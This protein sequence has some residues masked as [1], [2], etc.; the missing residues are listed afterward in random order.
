[1]PA[2]AP[3]P[4]LTE[5][6]IDKLPRIISD[7]R[8]ELTNEDINKIRYRLNFAD[9]SDLGKLSCIRVVDPDTIK[10]PSKES[11]TGC[12]Y[13]A[14][15]NREAEIWI[16]SELVKVPNRSEAFIYK[17]AYKDRLF[18]T[19]F[20]ELGHH[21]ATLTHS[22]DKFENEAFAEKYMLAYRKEWKRLYGPPK[23][24]QMLFRALIRIIRYVMLCMI[25]PFRNRSE[26]LNLFYR[27]LKGKITFRQYVKELYKLEGVE[28]EESDKT[29][30]KWIHPLNR[31]KYRERFTIPER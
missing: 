21:K 20:H 24:Y 13:P 12:Y 30:K 4:T 7:C 14:A 8:A 31:D 28:K 17:V 18:E 15:K 27:N 6:K 11:T 16:S 3:N 23:I 10:M 22:V 2:I 25:Y 29:K 9:H 26:E 5:D 1:M 19:L